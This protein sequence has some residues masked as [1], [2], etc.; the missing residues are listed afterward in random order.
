MSVPSP[1]TNNEPIVSFR[2]TVVRRFFGLPHLGGWLSI[3]NAAL[4]SIVLLA[5]FNWWFSREVLMLAWWIL[6][7]PLG[8]LAVIL[9]PPA[10]TMRPA[11]LEQ[12]CIRYCIICGVNSFVWGYITACV[13]DF[14]RWLRNRH[15][16]QS[17]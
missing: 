8:L 14:N 7:S 16:E 5:Y 17:R 6:A 13:L 10:P 11:E 12:L 15:S 2:R 3:V 1:A 4:L 9:L